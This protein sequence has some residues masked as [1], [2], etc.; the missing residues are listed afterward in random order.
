MPTNRRVK[1]RFQPLSNADE[2]GLRAGGVVIGAALGAGAAVATIAY[3]AQ[4]HHNPH[5]GLMIAICVGWGL[6]SASLLLLPRTR[7]VASRA[8]EPF[9]LAWSAA[10]VL[11]I[12]IGIVLEGNP[13]TPLALGFML[14]LIFAAMS[15]PV[16]GVAVVGAFVLL[17][18]AVTQQL[19][20]VPA[21]N[22][23][24]VL[25]VLGFASAMGLWQARDRA[26]RTAQLA[27]MAYHDML[28]GL[29]NRVQLEEHLT[30]AL[31]RARRH[32]GAGALLYVDL[33]HF[34]V[35]NDTLGHD[36]GD[37]L[38]REV[39]RRL[40][41]R[42]RAGD[43]LARHGGDEFMLLLAN[44]GNDAR[45]AADIVAHDLLAT[46]EQ[47]FTLQ[48]H[49]F[50]VAASIGAAIFP[51]DAGDATS[52][53]KHAD[54]ALYE[55]KR[56][57]RGGVRF[58]APQTGPSAEQ[59][60]LTARLRHAIMHGELELHYQPVFDVATRWPVAVEA[61]VRWRDPAIGLIPPGDFIPTAEDS[62]LI[63]PLGDWV[64][65]Q[66]LTQATAWRAQ[67]IAPEIAFNVSPRQL[68][69][70]GFADR[71]LARIRTSGVPPEQLI[72]EVT[73]SA[74]MTDPQ[75]TGPLLERLSQAG[76]RIAID[77]FGADFSSLAR[78]RDLPVDELK[79]DRAF[80]TNVPQDERSA[81]I[82]TAVIQLAQALELAAVAEGVEEPE[83]LEFLLLHGCDLAQGFHLGRP[84]QPEQ[85]EA[86]F[87]N[88][89]TPDETAA[90]WP[91][92]PPSSPS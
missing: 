69:A 27:S 40:S 29:A 79:I 39:A 59:L 19:D 5:R 86:L 32:G 3:L 25:T 14:P 9:F 24:F 18:A 67:G 37:E 48:G 87:R 84:V 88:A 56:D 63:E 62:G 41:A 45:R 54:T 78:L 15:Y 36:A 77:D 75:R 89:M 61:L 82:V 57:G 38:L 8:R 91:S 83:Q 49:V 33:D 42:T 64:I 13:H 28:T 11:S 51:R 53:L 68:T 81:A 4:T 60:T 85:I 34:K 90:Q 21:A 50:E 44:V 7:I 55:A 12:G 80:L 71:L 72:V 74:A 65:D 73:E 6:I 26:R 76:L 66:V 23:T 31:A 92:P 17:T 58:H 52:L 46:L 22:Q 47:P 2:I 20:H 30:V 70:A 16:A 35:V 1:L 10:V 43:V